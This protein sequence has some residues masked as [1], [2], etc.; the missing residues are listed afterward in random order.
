MK[1]TLHFLILC[2]VAFS[3]FGALH[4]QIPI[5]QLPNGGFENGWIREVS[6]EAKSIVPIGYHSFYSATGGVASLGKDQR[7][8]SSRDVR[9][10]ATGV[11][12]L[13]LFSTSTLGIRANGNVTTGRMNAGSISA[14]SSDNYNYTQIPDYCQEIT[15]T[16]DSLRFWVK[17][18]PGRSGATNTTDKGRIRVYIHGTGDC[19]D[20]P[21]YPSGMTETQLY[22]GKAMK[23]FYKE[24]GGWHAY[25]APFEYTGTNI[26]KN[27]NGNYYL[28]LS[29]TTNA[30][31]G[32]GANNADK[33][34][35]DDVEFVYSA[36]LSDLKINGTTID[37]FAKNLL[38]YGGPALTGS[39][40]YAFP[41]QPENFSW[42][43]EVNDVYNVVVTNVP[44]SNNDANGGY[45]SILVTAEDHVTQKEYKVYYFANLSS[46]NNMTAVSYT[47]DDVVITPVPSFTP[48]QTNYNIT[49]TNPEETRAPKI[50]EASIVLSASTATIQ[51]IE[52]PTG[53]N[54]K[55]MVVIQ[56][57]NF[58]LKSYNFMFSKLLSSNAKL[59]WIK[60]GDV[61]IAN[62]DADTLVYSYEIT[63]CTTSIPT[64][65]YE[66]ASAWATVQYTPA[67]L[68][69]RSATITVKAEDNTQRTYTINFVLKNNN[70]NLLGY[71]VNTTNQNNVFSATNFNHTYSA[72][73]TSV[74]TLSLSTTSGQQVCSGSTVLFPQTMVWYPDTNKINV[75]AQDLITKQTYGVIVKNTNCYLK[76]TSGSNIGLKYRYNG[77]V[78]NI[79]VPS[80]SN[81][82][83]V[84]IN[85]T[86]PV[87][88]PN[89][90]CELI[91]AD[92]QAPIVDTI[93][94]TQPTN[95]A[96][97]S[98]RVK[99]IANDG[100]TNKTYII[101]FTATISTDATL[102]NL[103][104]NGLQVPGFNPAT[105]FY[106]L[107]FPSNAT[108]VPEI[109][110]TPTFQWL[111]ETNI[112]VMQATSFLD[113]TVIV[114]TAENGTTTK[115]YRI[116]YE[117]VAQEKDAY[118]TD[119]KYENI[120]INGFNPTIYE[121][122]IDVPYAA[123]TP[124]QV[125]PFASS[126]TALI[127]PSIQTNTPPYTQR[128]LVY[129]EDMTVTKIYKVDFNRVKNT[130]AALADIKINGIS[131]EDFNAELFEYEYEL[132]YTEL[133]AP[134]VTA[135][136]AYQY[137]NVLT[138]QIDTV[139][140]TVTIHVTAEDDN[141]TATYTVN[142][143]RVLSP[144]TDIETITYN[145]NN[146]T[147]TYSM[148]SA[149]EVT[150]MLPVETLGE[151][152]I[153]N[154]VLTDHR[155]TF[156][157][158]QPNEANNYTGTI[159]VTAEDLTEETYFISFQRTLSESTLITEITYNGIPVLNFDPDILNYAV[160]LPYNN[161]QIPVVAAT[162]AWINTNISYDQATNP[163]GQATILVTSENGQHFKTY[164]IDFQRQ[165]NPL[166][167]SLSYN[168]DG[169]SNP[170]LGFTPSV[171]T[172]NVTLPIANTAVPVLEYLLED[173]RCEVVEVLQSSPN[174][175]SSLTITTWN[176]EETVTYTVNFT[177]ELST[178]A[179]LLDLQV[180]G[181]T[182]TGFN[183]ALQNYTIQYGYG[184]V[185]LPEVTAIATKPDATV[186]ITQIEAYP[187]VATVNVYAGDPAFN[188]TY[189]I[190]FSV[191][192]GDNTYLSDLTVGG[193]TIFGFDK[194]TCFYKVDLEYGTTQLI[195][196][197]ASPEDERS[198]VE[199]TQATLE[200]PTAT[201]TV[202]A[203]NGDSAIYQVFFNIKK[204]PN[205]YA[206][207]IYVDWKPLEDFVPYNL[208]YSCHLPEGYT[209]ALSVMVELVNP[210][211]TYDYIRPTTFPLI[212]QVI[213]TAEDGEN[214]NIY[215]IHFDIGTGI[216]TFN[217]ET[218]ILVYPNP[219]SNIIHFSI[220]AENQ[221]SN[222]EL[223]S[224][225]GKKV[226]NHQLQG[227]T[228]TINIEH[229]PNGIYFY[230]VSL[231]KAQIGTGKFVKQ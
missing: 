90:P 158:E 174:G 212:G 100:T 73:L 24:D 151:P 2:L 91:E 108:V 155:A 140:G 94:Y 148:G 45:T 14:G 21:A 187:G 198:T 75:T 219:S 164:T 25:Q 197:G 63:A 66:K 67:T 230:K 223:Y 220:N 152:S 156:E 68:S 213:V 6:N 222:L 130:N 147:Y 13:S 133:N 10:G 137:A 9:V 162:V 12:S 65:T 41:Y 221:A 98:G 26:Q 119:I 231:D 39:A 30:T 121:Y 55:G 35:F 20:A 136:P 34:W 47:I 46:N 58:S 74:F 51:R 226:A 134:V 202:K 79:T 40:P 27:A 42:T 80:A 62:F 127:F 112:D 23:E 103:T 59:N 82:N 111:P 3:F 167:V 113:T 175:T 153:T 173:E 16:P 149:T 132:P 44:G 92:P 118:L 54:S 49:I 128:F 150:I 101:N 125:M 8:D 139:I 107:I 78:R 53:V 165:G 204:N 124:P 180:N 81:N 129:S 97:N 224:F 183:P 227:G 1:K 144:V 31:P 109:G 104:Y 95:R 57:E 177:V 141:Y 176:E 184:T 138:I 143:T 32:G 211:A 135:I 85:V 196:V 182:V 194:N 210:N 190:S 38:T 181:E 168:L 214:Q 106:T 87:T 89:V 29:M 19:R 96:G 99:V 186:V 200:T 86:I 199:I 61:V 123:P 122:L 48:S 105:E 179:L 154:V 217:N 218:E 120:S 37:G 72:S 131:L 36:W 207:M 228:N 172:Y 15:G 110:F 191:E 161:S 93:V 169:V 33:V 229:L 209:G 216:P 77:V 145:Y 60:I 201:V 171:F 43:T 5:Y 56:A 64:V 178:E 195:E 189:T 52:Q 4:A 50:V 88:G 188:R 203:L 146:E 170:V 159:N 71:R 17:Y 69:N 166:L 192:S 84:T 117:V 116:A 215:L 208:S 18:L 114:V 76:Q 185:E 163:F 157:F 70:A 126:P 102:S 115:T 11:Y 22:Y 7:C 28:L 206:K 225:E 205:A 83:D 193:Y 160:I 142:F